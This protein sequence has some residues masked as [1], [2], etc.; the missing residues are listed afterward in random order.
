MNPKIL[1]IRN[2]YSFDFGGAEIFP[3]NVAKLLN[4]DGYKTLL[5]SSNKKTLALAKKSGVNAQHSPWWSLQDQSGYKILLFPIYLL[6]SVFLIAW[7]SVFIL[8]NNIDVVYPQGRDDFVSATIAGKILRKRVVWSDHADLKHIY[9]NHAVW[10]KNPIGK[11]VYLTS[12]LAN[13]V[14]LES[15]SEKKLT[16]QSLGKKLPEH[17]SVIHIGVVDSYAPAKTKSSTHLTLVATS[18]MVSD[19]GIGELIEAV[20]LL[21]DPKVILKLCGTGPEIN[22]FKA[23]AK[24]AHNIEFLG[25]IDDVSTV[26]QQAD[27]FIHPTYHEGFGLSLVE[28]EMFNLPIIASNVGSIPEIVSDGVSG[29]LIP[30]KNPQALARAIKTLVDDPQLRKSM[31]KAGRDIYLKNF[32][33]DKI[34][35]EKFLPLYEK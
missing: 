27:I 31:G 28:A 6:W 26:L 13:H 34:V 35:R 24:N 12:L 4:Q 18:R 33:F 2:S 11:L 21:D 30:P 29:L 1:L 19:K 3:V 17:Y 10:Y 9:K 5:L 16:E 7:Y 20:L 15:N 8:R 25:H 14:T 23:Q 32:Q 22:H